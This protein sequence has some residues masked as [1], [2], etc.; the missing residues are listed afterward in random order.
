MREMKRSGMRIFTILKMLLR[1]MKGA[2][3]FPYVCWCANRWR[4][5]VGPAETKEYLRLFHKS[6]AY[7]NG[8]VV[9]EEPTFGEILIVRYVGNYFLRRYYKYLKT[10]HRIEQGVAS[11]A[12]RFFKSVVPIL[13]G[14][15]REL[16]MF[17]KE[18][19]FSDYEEYSVHDLN[20]FKECRGNIFTPNM[21]YLIQNVLPLRKS[22]VNVL[23][24]TY[25]EALESV[26][27][28]LVPIS[29]AQSKLKFV[30]DVFENCI[31][32]SEDLP[33]VFS[34]GMGTYADILTRWALMEGDVET[35]T[36]AIDAAQKMITI[37]QLFCAGR[38]NRQYRKSLSWYFECIGKAGGR[39]YARLIAPKRL[40]NA[41][42]V[43]P[44]TKLEARDA[45][46][47]ARLE[48]RA[49]ALERKFVAA[50]IEIDIL[51]EE[52]KSV[53]ANRTS[54]RTAR[55]ATIRVQRSVHRTEWMN[56]RDAVVAW[57][58]ERAAQ[59]FFVQDKSSREFDRLFK[60]CQPVKFI[61]REAFVKVVNYGK[62]TKEEREKGFREAT[63][64]EIIDSKGKRLKKGG[65][66]AKKV[67]E[68]AHGLYLVCTDAQWFYAFEAAVKSAP[69]PLINTNGEWKVSAEE[70]WRRVKNQVDHGC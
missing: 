57:L 60:E 19:R 8:C 47:I 7:L 54:M 17:L 12:F 35:S 16:K 51:K 11:E 9:H 53:I 58:M 26:R 34:V 55:E 1:V 46:K 62:R 43:L 23:K 14:S 70:V 69:C 48:S 68:T 22:V 30:F 45:R 20:Y 67:D 32:I 65:T 18:F 59:M 33:R 63:V 5:R 13:V 37:R 2:M 36:L 24:V 40:V 66:A 27:D 39:L 15:L 10:K 21:V 6:I 31:G 3:L 25:D 44:P 61:A 42:E 38:L 41:I 29:P 64:G 56:A 50:R 49:N 52:F 28:L 4:Y